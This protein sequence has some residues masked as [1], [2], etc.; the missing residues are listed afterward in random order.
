MPSQ[1]I[2]IRPVRPD[3]TAL[4][5]S[6]L[7]IAARM[8]E[9]DEPMQKALA[10]PGLAKYWQG[11]GREGDLGF[12]AESPDGL[13][14]SC[15]WVRLFSAEDG[16]YG[17]VSP[18]IPELGVGTIPSARS[19]GIG[20]AVLECLLKS[21]EERFPGVSLSVREESP[22]VRLYERLGFERVPSSEELN[23]VQTVSI[24]ML[25]RFGG[26]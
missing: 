11:W 9:A 3:E 19:Q 7:V 23:R 5:F 6:F 15:A 8:E 12:V 2:Q 22:A 20:T 14:L 17:Q 13:P 10:D 21:C 26:E 18:E 25:L 1:P 24:T 16:G 4:V